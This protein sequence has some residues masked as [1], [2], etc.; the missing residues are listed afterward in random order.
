MNHQ[1]KSFPRRS[2]LT[3]LQTEWSDYNHKDTSGPGTY[4][5]GYDVEDS[6]TNNV[7]FRNEEKHFNG[8]VTGSYGY[9]Q[10]DGNILI[11]HYIADKLGYR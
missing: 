9:M 1:I 11:V 3:S 5:F 2:K 8:T 10:P 7:Q 4:I 6:K